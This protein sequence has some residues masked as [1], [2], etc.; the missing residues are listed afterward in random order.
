SLAEMA[1]ATLWVFQQHDGRFPW[2]KGKKLTSIDSLRRY[3]PLAREYMRG[4]QMRQQLVGW[5][6]DPDCPQEAWVM[7]SH[8]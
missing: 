2:P 6:E 5:T 7:G 1:E 3:F 8:R 4:E